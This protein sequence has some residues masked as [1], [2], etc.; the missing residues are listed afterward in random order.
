[1]DKKEIKLDVWVN[2]GDARTTIYTADLT[3]GY[4]KINAEYN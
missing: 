4:V 3:H 2:Q 1:L